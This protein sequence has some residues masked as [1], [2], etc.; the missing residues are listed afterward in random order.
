VTTT[1]LLIVCATSLAALVLLARELRQ[2]AAARAQHQRE[3]AMHERAAAVPTAAL[4]DATRALADAAAAVSRDT[5]SRAPSRVGHRVTVHTKRDDDHTI[6]GVV[7]ADYTDRLVLRD[8]EYVTAQGPRPIPGHEHHI[9]H[10]NISWIDSV[11]VVERP[12][13]EDAPLTGEVVA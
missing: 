9:P 12:A 1:H 5:A 4:A 6:Y 7:A 11:G 8:A 10:A 3:L 13:L 2:H